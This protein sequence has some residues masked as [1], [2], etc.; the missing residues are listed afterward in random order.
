MRSFHLV[1]IKPS[2]YDD[3]GY[4]IQWIRSEIP[5]NTLA[6]VNG[7]ALDCRRR[8]VLGPD[9]DLRLVTLD[10]TN[11]RIKPKAIIR[12]IRRQSGQA[13][14]AL[15]GVQSNQFNRAIDLARPFLKEGLA[16]AIGGFHV[17]GCLAMLPELPAEIRQAQDMGISIFAGEAEDGALDELLR[18]AHAGS[19]KPLYNHMKHLPALEGQPVPILPAEAVRR[20]RGHFSSFDLGRGCPFQCSFC[21]II[22]VQGRKSR[23]RTPDD[24]E[25][26][27]R[28]NARQGIH[29]FFITDDNFARNREWEPLFDRLISLRE[30]EGLK[31]KLIIQVDTLCHRIPRFIE[32]ACR[33]GVTRVFIGLENINPDN[34]L[35]AK[36]RQ[37]KITDYR[38]M[39]QAW[40]A[41]GAT[42]Y[43]GYILG[44]PND[45]RESILR[46]VEIIKRELPIDLLEFNFLTPLPGSED[47]KNLLGD[48]RWMD[49]DL[50][51]YDLHHR[52]THHEKMSDAEW[53]QVYREAWASYYTPEHLETV[54]RRAACVP[55][56]RPGGKMR[57]MMWFSLMFQIEGLHPLEGGF[58]R[59]KYRIDRRPSL[60]L[61]SPFVFYPKY[62]AEI[63]AKAYRYLM[64]VRKANRIY[65]R[66]MRDPN[67]AVYTDTAIMPPAA[68]DFETLAMF[69]ETSGGEAAVAKKLRA[70]DLRARFEAAE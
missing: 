47:H 59:R 55:K 35:A 24:L 40:R 38:L 15:I 26:I 54:I 41:H 6:A 62:A 8:Q 13:L 30:G 48:G 20:T 39:L 14:V 17:S 19:L 1:M 65:R 25:R 56:G 4:P 18:D 51:K 66:V 2:H 10:E 32:K 57:V 63:I 23:F 22:N 61:E 12:K 5:A 46:D 50:N 3:D 36:K 44:F 45:T 64:M 7:L 11:T 67:R 21:T 69:T 33:A 58:F 31:I 37:N 70:E 27:I 34:L 49:P 42:T 60:P 53:D 16:V 52:V 68:D 29:C 9:V 43:A 28:D